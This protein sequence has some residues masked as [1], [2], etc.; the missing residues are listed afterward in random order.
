MKRE[1][2]E[3]VA[4]QALAYLEQCRVIALDTR[5]ALHAAELCSTMKLATADAVIYA[6][7][8]EAGARLLTCDAHFKDLDGVVFIAKS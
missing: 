1:V 6:T 4:D 3:D 8:R 5:I 2:S 7:A